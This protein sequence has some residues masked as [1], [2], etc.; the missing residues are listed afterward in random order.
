MRTSRCVKSP[1]NKKW[2]VKKVL[3][4]QQ[5]DTNFKKWQLFLAKTRPKKVAIVLPTLSSKK[6][7]LTG[8]KN[9]NLRAGKLHL[10]LP[11]KLASF[12]F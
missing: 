12:S 5:T 7:G 6:T 8:N 2:Q 9:H 1:S 3:V 10:N 11:E 4:W